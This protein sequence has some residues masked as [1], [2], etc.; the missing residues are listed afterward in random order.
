MIF[1][2][3]GAECLQN[4]V[5]VFS[6]ALDGAPRVQSI[7][8]G[9]TLRNLHL[10]SFFIAR[11]GL[12]SELQLGFISR[13]FFGY[14]YVFQNLGFLPSRTVRDGEMVPKIKNKT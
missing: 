5:G 13:T 4:L 7:L 6:N 14:V 1:C 12:A 8:K 9:L 3:R 10:V 2:V 11:T